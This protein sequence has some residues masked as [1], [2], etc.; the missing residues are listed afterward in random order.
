[1]FSKASI[2]TKLNIKP[3]AALS[4]LRQRALKFFSTTK[5]AFF[6]KDASKKIPICDEKTIHKAFD[7]A[8]L[9]LPICRIEH[10]RKGANLR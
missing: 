6:L 2:L 7:S 4:G 10:D 5:V 8:C 3:F 9:L 1:L